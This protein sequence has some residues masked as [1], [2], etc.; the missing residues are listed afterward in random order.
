VKI[1]HTGKSALRLL[2]NLKAEISDNRAAGESFPES[3]YR[4]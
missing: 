2:R 3:S 4:N 1:L